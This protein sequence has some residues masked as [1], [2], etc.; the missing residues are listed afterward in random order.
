MLVTLQG[1]ENVAAWT[2]ASGETN[3]TGP[4]LI[5]VPQTPILTHQGRHPIGSGT[6]IFCCSSKTCVLVLRKTGKKR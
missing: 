5:Y 2:S 3:C 4:R 6:L 1:L